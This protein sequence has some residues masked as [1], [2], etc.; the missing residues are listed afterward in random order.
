MKRRTGAALPGLGEAR[1]SAG[2]VEVEEGVELHHLLGV[3]EHGGAGHTCE[4]R[5]VRIRTG[6]G[7][8]DRLKKHEKGEITLLEKI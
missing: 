4:G 7:R 5:Q 8:E 6:E 2:D 1:G 3:E